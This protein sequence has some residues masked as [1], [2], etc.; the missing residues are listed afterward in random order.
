[1][2]SSRQA[3][4]MTTS[5]QF[6]DRPPEQGVLLPPPDRRPQLWPGQPPP[7]VLGGREGMPE[8]GRLAHEGVL[9]RVVDEVYVPA[10]VQDAPALRAAAVHALVSVALLSAAP[11]ICWEAAGWVYCGGPAPERVDLAVPA[12]ASRSLVR[13]PLALHEMR[14]AR[15]DLREVGATRLRITSPARTAVDLARRLPHERA[16][17]MMDELAVDAGLTPPALLARLH[18]MQRYRDITRAR[19]AA[20]AWVAR[21]QSERVPVTR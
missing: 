3:L 10:D 2:V 8:A 18:A 6:P 16:L 5:A 1:M 11:V 14:M 12:P 17:T 7:F 19:L 20:A 4:P 21:R 13:A 15:A 9:R